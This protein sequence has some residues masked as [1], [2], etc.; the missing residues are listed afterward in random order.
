M[1]KEEDRSQATN[2]NLQSSKSIFEGGDTLATSLA[3]I[4]DRHLEIINNR[5][6]N[7]KEHLTTWLQDTLE[8]FYK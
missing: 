4:H 1:T 5:E 8:E 7:L 3:K 2:E 6:K